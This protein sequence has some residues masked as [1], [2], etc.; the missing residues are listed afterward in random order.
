MDR[1]AYLARIDQVNREGRYHPDWDSLATHPVPDWYREKR[2]GIFLHWGVFSV[3]AYHDWYA[4]NMYIEGSEEYEYHLK[5][6][7]PHKTF[8]FKDFIPSFTMS[9]STRTRGRRC[10]RA[11]A[12]I[13]SSRWR[14]I[15]T[16]SRITGASCPTGTRRKWAPTAIFWATCSPPPSGR[17]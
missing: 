2:L 13:T 9:A 11:S 1:A 14:S 5:H 15:T 12:R 7:G 8:G 6:Y 17:G 3:P 4:R 16:A 10:S